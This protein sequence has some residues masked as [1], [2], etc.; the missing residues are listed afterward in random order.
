MRPIK[1]VVVDDSL[2]M[3]QLITR[4]LTKDPNIE[5]VGQASD[6]HQARTAIKKLNPDVITLD[7]EMPNMDGLEFLDKIMRLRPMPVVMVSTLTQKGAT[8]TIKALELGAID[9]V[10]K[11]NV[12]NPD[13]FD[14]LSAIVR[15]AA[16][17]RVQARRQPP[18]T[19]GQPARDTQIGQRSFQS[20]LIAIGSSTGGVEA[21]L[22]VLRHF[23]ENCPPTVITQHMPP[24]F[25]RSLAER[26]NNSA[27]PEVIEAA[28][29]MTVQPGRV[30]IAP[31][32]EHH[33]AIEGRHSR[34]CRL[35]KAPLINGHRPS[36]DFLFRSVAE[37]VGS[38]SVGVILTGMGSD[39]AEGLLA[40]RQ[41]GART[42]G[43]NEATSVVY[44]M[45]KAAF[46]CGAV[47]RQM[48]IQ[49]IAAEALFGTAH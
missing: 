25:T 39:G 41:T 14:D 8:A 31:G 13:S 18:S 20:E 47:G 19:N 38:R 30:V 5:V 35:R 42:I 21:L 15:Q 40:M 7:I 6:P 43:Q 26:L 22:N 17:A 48:P 32:G 28:D 2:V 1:A 23:P 36:V 16:A 11:P 37:T 9:C 27:A 49:E 33:L 29:G 46:E 45:P 3:R 24:L 12:D 4:S 34:V 44:G 10:G